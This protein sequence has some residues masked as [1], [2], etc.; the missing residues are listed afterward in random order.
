MYLQEEK[1]EQFKQCRENK[2]SC[3]SPL[4]K[5][6][7]AYSL[8]RINANSKKVGQERLRRMC[9]QNIIVEFRLIFSHVPGSVT[10]GRAVCVD[11][12]AM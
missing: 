8:K 9:L 11:R 2:Y 10:V 12:V 6:T 1:S 7:G 4:Q 3:Y 5:Q